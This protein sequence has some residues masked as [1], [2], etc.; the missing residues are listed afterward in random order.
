MG[1][2]SYHNSQAYTL[3]EPIIKTSIRDQKIII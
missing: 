1:A 3:K 2:N